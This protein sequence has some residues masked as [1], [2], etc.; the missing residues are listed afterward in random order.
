MVVVGVGAV[1]MVGA[2]GV[3]G[4]IVMVGAGAVVGVEMAGII[5]IVYIHFILAN[6][7]VSGNLVAFR[8]ERHIVVPVRK[9][10]IHFLPIG[11]EWFFDVV[12]PLAVGDD[13][14]GIIVRVVFL[15]IRIMP[16]NAKVSL[17]VVTVRA[18]RHIVVPV[19][20]TAILLGPIGTEWHFDVLCPVAYMRG[21]LYGYGLAGK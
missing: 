7:N 15:I 2:I 16:A 3:G 9:T 18:E 11:T 5:V 6:A 17:D 14:V 1:V 20:K 12:C 19:R 21:D 8:A 13:S 4:V 10:A